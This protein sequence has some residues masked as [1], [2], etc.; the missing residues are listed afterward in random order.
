M[1]QDTTR[2]TRRIFTAASGSVAVALSETQ[3]NAIDASQKEIGR[4]WAAARAYTLDLLAAMPSE[5][6]PYVAFEGEY[7]FVKHLT[8]LGYYNAV[9]V[10]SIST[11]RL[12][13]HRSI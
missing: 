11:A 2:V 10:G 5:Y 12:G 3:L 4:R 6:L 8:H 7:S 9:L 13:I 1:K